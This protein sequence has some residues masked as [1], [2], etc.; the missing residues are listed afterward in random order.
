MKTN[1]DT[2]FKT[3]PDY[4]K[5]GVWFDINDKTGFLVRPFKQ[6]NPR[7]KAALAAHYKPYARQIEMNT[8]DLAKQQ[9]INIRLFLDVCL[10]GWKGVEIDDV[11]TPFSREVALPFFVSL[12]DLFDTLWKHANDFNN[13][14]E[15]VGNS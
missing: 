11:D 1:L 10:V 14:K 7:V 6:T 8:L 3:N 4:E 13:F 12:P 2:I 5:N 15:D 9:E